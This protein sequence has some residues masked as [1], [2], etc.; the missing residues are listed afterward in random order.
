MDVALEEAWGALQRGEVPIGCAIY[1]QD[2]TLL[3]T[4]S[5]RTNERG[6]A[7]AHAELVALEQLAQRTQRDLQTGLRHKRLRLY[8]TCEPCV[9]CAAAILHCGV[10]ARVEYGCA[11]ARFGGCGTVKH[12]LGSTTTT[13]SDADTTDLQNNGDYTEQQQREF[14][15]GD[16]IVD[17]SVANGLDEES[18]TSRA[19]TETRST[20]VFGGVRAKECVGLLNEFYRRANPNA[21][22]P[23][24]KKKR[25][26]SDN[27]DV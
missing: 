27:A 15:H 21:P 4:G 19:E 6:N 3:A 10:F 5:N 24:V 18:R 12:I 22:R 8:V 26:R 9:M 17:D 16:E 13:A 14:R 11:N 7:T 25:A 2:G 1:S 20:T 23:K